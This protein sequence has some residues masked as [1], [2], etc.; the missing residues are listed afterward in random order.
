[1][2]AG[3]GGRFILHGHRPNILGF[4]IRVTIYYFLGNIVR[5]DRI[6]SDTS[7]RKVVP[8]KQG[9]CVLDRLKI[10]SSRLS[11]TDIASLVPRLFG[12]EKRAWYTPFVHALK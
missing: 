8:C 4:T 2:A 7:S 5:G 9:L 12:G 3:E 11:C 6:S 1:M 10:A